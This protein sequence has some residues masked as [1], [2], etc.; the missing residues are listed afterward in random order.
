MS[1]ETNLLNAGGGIVVAGLIYAGVSM[2]ATGPL[3]L[4]RTIQK[5]GWLGRCERLIKIELASQSAHHATNTPTMRCRDAVGMLGPDMGRLFRHFGGDRACA[6]MDAKVAAARRLERLKR[7]GF[8][9]ASSRARSRCDCAVSQAI[10][11]NRSAVGLYA[12]SARLIRSNSI[13]NLDA[14]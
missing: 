5:S 8:K 2:Y 4:D 11:T 14:A 10:D 1:M 6:M 7:E 9:A 12:G 3:I 13:V